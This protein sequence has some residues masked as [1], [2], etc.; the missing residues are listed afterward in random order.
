MAENEVG[1]ILADY[2]RRV[3]S[4]E[5]IDIDALCRAHPTIADE[6]R[7]YVGGAALVEDFIRQGDTSKAEAY[8]DTSRSKTSYDTDTVVVG[9]MFG[10]YRIKQ[11]LG[12][13]AMGAVYLA[14]DTQLDREVAIKIPKV[15]NGEHDEFLARFRWEAQAAAKLSHPGICSVF[16]FGEFSNRPYITM[17]YI[18]GKPLS[19]FIGGDELS[20]KEIMQIVRDIADALQHSHSMGVIHRDLK[21]GNVMINE[22]GKPIVTD[23]G[24]ARKVDQS[25]ESRITREGALLGTPGYMAPEQVEADVQKIGPATDIYALGVILYE[26]ISGDLPFRGSIHSILVQITRDEPR[27]PLDFNPDADSRLCQFCLQMIAKE[28]ENRPQSMQEVVD[29]LDQ[30]AT[31]PSAERIVEKN[32]KSPRL[33]KLDKVKRKVADLVK[34]GQY[35][36]AVSLLEKMSAATD[37]QAAGYASW[38]LNELERVKKLPQKIR[39]GIPTLVGTARMFMQKYDYARAAQ[40]LQ[41]IPQKMRSPV[42]EQTLKNAI[43]L[44]DE[45]NMLLKT[46]KECCKSQNCAGIEANVRRLLEIKPDNQFARDLS[47]ALQTYRHIPV[48]R[49][50][51]AFDP[52]GK[53]LPLEKARKRSTR[54]AMILATMICLGGIIYGVTFLIKAGDVTLLVKTDDELLKRGD[55]TLK[56]DGETHLISGPEF[57]LTV[58]PGEYGYEVRQGDIVVRNPEKF[59]VRKNGRN[60]LTIEPTAPAVDRAAQSDRDSKSSVPEQPSHFAEVHGVTKSEL[61]SWLESIRGEYIPLYINLRWGASEWIFDATAERNTTG[62]NWVVNFFEN[63]S[64]AFEFSSKYRWTHALYWRLL[65]PTEGVRPQQGPGLRIRREVKR[66]YKPQDIKDQDFQEAVDYYSNRKWFPMSL[67]TTESAGHEYNFFLGH[68]RGDIEHQSFVGLTQDEFENKVEEFEGKSWILHFFQ[69]QAGTSTPRINCTFCENKVGVSSATSFNLTESQY[70]SELE[71]RKDSGW[72]PHCVG[73]SIDDG[74]V[75]Y[76]VNWR[77]HATSSKFVTEQDNRDKLPPHWQNLPADSPPPAIAPF[78]SQQAST[79]QKQW[80]EHLGVPVEF[81]DKFGFT[82]R[83]IPPGEFDMG[84]SETELDNWREHAKSGGEFWERGQISEGPQHRVALT[85]PYYLA[86]TEVTQEQFQS[87][88]SFNPSHFSPENNEEFKNLSTA[89]F[90]VETI[91]WNQTQEF[92]KGLHAQ[93]GLTGEDQSQQFYRLPTEAEWEFACRAGTNTVYWTGDHQDT[94]LDKENLEGLHGRPLAVGSLVP[95]PFGLFDMAGNVHEYVN[96]RWSSQQ[97]VDEGKSITIDPRGATDPNLPN[98]VVRGGDFYWWHYHSRSA[99]RIS[100]HQEVPSGIAIGFRIAANIDAH[101]FAIDSRANET[102]QSRFSETHGATKAELQD[103]LDS[104]QGKYYPKHIN[105]RWGTSDVLFD[106]VAL[107]TVDGAT[108]QVSFFENDHQAGQ[109]Y[110]QFGK[111]HQLLWKLLFPNPNA[112]P[113]EGPGLK[114]W[115]S[116][117]KGYLTLNIG[118]KDL[119]KAVEEVSSDGWMPVSLVCSESANQR[120]N[121]FVCRRHFGQEYQAFVGLTLGEF[122]SKTKE[123]G[124]RG[125]PLSFFQLSA[126]TTELKVSC[127]FHQSD[128]NDERN[129]SFDLTEQQYQSMLKQRGSS[130]WFPTCVG[131]YIQQE[132]PS[133]IVA[134]RR[135]SIPRDN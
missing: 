109:D 61:Q 57:I 103:W 35:G 9:Q 17:A 126:G 107:P 133:Y 88:L 13:G 40:I 70:E 29:Q 71:Q 33:K 25:E 117:G 90:P 85:K 131:S 30:Y 112:V 99:Y 8:R 62:R 59:T 104:I 113:T 56:F 116:T 23:F 93:L 110:K 52:Y 43:D 124:A 121:S 5:Q 39:E 74:T 92:L 31:N 68:Q 55:I 15:R 22:E 134:W 115:R 72:A 42:I 41:Q 51:Y 89:K 69:L 114:I 2:M 118:E 81:T 66:T 11:Q 77:K 100:C 98:R 18:N 16:D 135:H 12:E 6:I 49:R 79:Y 37:T 111:T 28:I 63:D 73:S 44:Q 120:N 38:A 122:K 46:L 83:L 87:I 26:L 54:L 94:I 106:A 20:Q 53:L 21:S 127:V 128:D 97:Y 34:R 1:E 47:E 45:A 14:I 86:T 91:S 50:E 10:R 102:L 3:D 129:I 48:E 58:A 60:V 96:D 82:F 19:Q 67:C 64:E 95:N 123:F 108:F 65:F 76:L 132:I 27:N 101:K 75:S 7:A 36:Q 24:L 125:W 80:A 4:G 32:D 84:S 78:N 119:Q 105:L 130:G